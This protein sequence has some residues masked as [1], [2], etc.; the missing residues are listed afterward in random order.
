MFHDI[1][2]L[3]FHPL[4]ISQFLQHHSAESDVICRWGDPKQGGW[5]WELHQAP[6][7][8]PQTQDAA[9]LGPKP[10]KVPGMSHQAWSLYLRGIEPAFLFH[11]FKISFSLNLF[12]I[13]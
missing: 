9:A 11:F 5:R 3:T 12:S 8:L 10:T 7:G 6:R 4:D 13:N 2:P 1:F